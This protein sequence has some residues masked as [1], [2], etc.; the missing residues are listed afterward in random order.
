MQEK[1]NPALTF[2]IVT[3]LAEGADR[4][5]AKEVL[6]FPE[7]EIEV[8]LPFARDDYIQDFKTEESQQAFEEFYRK[9]QNPI[10][11]KNNLSAGTLSAIERT[12]ARSKAYEDVG[13]YVVTHCDVLIA[14]WD[15]RPSRGRGGTAEIAAF[16][17]KSKCPLIV[18]TPDDPVSVT[19]ERG[20]GLMR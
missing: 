2:T 12:K 20:R 7:S 18:I 6:K 13:R 16:A 3:P 4:L 17:R 15:G 8:V 9:S 14:L 11:L 1:T 19:F 5:I 10:V